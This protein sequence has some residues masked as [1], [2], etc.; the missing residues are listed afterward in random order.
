MNEA[1][2]IHESDATKIINNLTTELDRERD[3]ISQLS[4][5]SLSI[6]GKLETPKETCEINK[7]T[8]NLEPSFLLEITQLLR[9]LRD[10]NDRFDGLVKTLKT[11]V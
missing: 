2:A 7:E 6:T 10:S 5:I 3:L 8:Q 4:K 1:K 11:F 9:T